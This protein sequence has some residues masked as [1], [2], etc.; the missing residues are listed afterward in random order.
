MST[1]DILIV[2]GVFLFGLL[3]FRDGFFRKLF[4]ILG[5]LLGLIVATKFM[6]GLGENI[7]VWM[8]F[9]PE[10]SNVLAYAFLFMLSVVIVNVLFRW[11]GR[12]SKEAL[13]MRSRFAGSLLGL[14]QGLVGVSLIL[15][16]LN[17][18]E[19]PSENDKEESVFYDPMSSIAPMVFDYAT[20]W[21]PAS[22]DFFEEIK[23][24]IEKTSS[25][26]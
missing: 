9:S 15:L 23:S 18:Y 25:T 5:I 24:K 2:V 3:G 7:M 4:G 20:S 8:D 1:T 13:S 12:S 19:I 16:M 11:F 6:A 10:T 21:M 17:S 14:V 26:E 22:K